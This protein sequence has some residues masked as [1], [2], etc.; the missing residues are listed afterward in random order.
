MGYLNINVI[1]NNFL[2]TSIDNLLSLG[3]ALLKFG[4]RAAPW[5]VLPLKFLE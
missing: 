1:E 3:Q 2:A 5:H 4:L